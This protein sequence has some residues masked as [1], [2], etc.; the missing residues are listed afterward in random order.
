MI[1]LVITTVAITVA[2][3]LHDFSHGLDFRSREFADAL[4]ERERRIEA[5]RNEARRA[6]ATDPHQHAA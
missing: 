4:A 6:L 2:L 3:V 5:R 1:Y